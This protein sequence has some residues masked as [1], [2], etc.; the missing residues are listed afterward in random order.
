MATLSV[1]QSRIYF[2]DLFPCLVPRWRKIDLASGKTVRFHTFCS[3]HKSC[4]VGYHTIL[5]S[6]SLFL[7]SVGLKQ[8]LHLFVPCSFPKNKHERVKH[9]ILHVKIFPLL[10]ALY[11]YL[12]RGTETDTTRMQAFFCW[13]TSNIPAAPSVARLKA[14][15]QKVQVPMELAESSVLGHHPLPPWVS[16]RRNMGTEAR[17]SSWSHRQQ[18]RHLHY[19]AK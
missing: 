14:R 7:L 1:L 10:Y 11:R 8:Y 19:L 15:T 2:W 5:L 17:P 13:T 9:Q 4:F 18:P 3:A 12:L 16:M 6:G